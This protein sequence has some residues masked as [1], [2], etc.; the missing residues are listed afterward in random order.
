MSVHVTPAMLEAVAL[1]ALPNSLD[2]PLAEALNRWLPEYGIDTPLRVAHLLAQVAH[3]TGGFVHFK[4]VGGAAYF[5]RRYGGREDLGNSR[6]GDG[7]RYRGRGLLQITGRFNYAA[8]GAALGLDLIGSPELAEE[9]ET[10]VRIA[11][12]YWRTRKINAKADA[13]LIVGVT[14]KINGGVLGLDDR[15]RRLAAVRPL[16][17]LPEAA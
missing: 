4:E 6:P 11:G 3:E 1:R 12:W 8:A 13:D 5:E 10:S 2:R 9:V 15:K 16:L 17:D 7:A 14:R